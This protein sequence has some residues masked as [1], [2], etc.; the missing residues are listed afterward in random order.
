MTPGGV[1][2]GAIR[3]VP[4]P[5][6]IM[7]PGQVGIP[8]VGYDFGI[9]RCKNIRNIFREAVISRYLYIFSHICGNNSER[10]AI[11]IIVFYAAS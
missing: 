1:I 6:E 9:R 8:D 7:I 4:F 2:K 11:F 3:C 5:S 10:R